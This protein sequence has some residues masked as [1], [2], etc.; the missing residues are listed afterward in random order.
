MKSFSFSVAAVCLFGAL[1]CSDD[2]ATGSLGGGA[3][4]GSV[5]SGGSA[6][7]P[8]GTAGGGS[9]FGGG[10]AGGSSAGAPAA[11]SGG[12]ATAGSAGASAGGGGSAGE[13]PLPT[14][15]V[16]LYGL[17]CAKCHAE[18]GRGGMNGPEIVHP[19][20]EYSSWVVRNGRAM[21][22]FP[23]PMEKWGADKL[24]DAQLNLIFD[25]LDTPPQ[26]TT[27]AE[28]YRDYCTNCHGSDAK[29]GPAMKNLLNEVDE[30]KDQVRKGAH[31]GEY[32]MRQ[33]YMPAFSTMRLSDADLDKIY[34]YV[35]GL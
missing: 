24:S 3:T 30:L 28:L 27:G 5:A 34:Q 22:S 33:E 25:Y 4:A 32:S 11:G 15:G 6:G 31:P 23:M 21:T 20:R 17:H 7:A 1:G 29:S 10:S 16:G 8:T 13:G 26:P 2:L 18:Q 9:G 12:M 35:D 14:D 19:V